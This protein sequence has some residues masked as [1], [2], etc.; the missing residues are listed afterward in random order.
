MFFPKASNVWKSH[1]QAGIFHWPR[2]KSQWLQKWIQHLRVSAVTRIAT[3]WKIESTYTLQ[4]INISHLGKRKI[5]FKMPFLGDVLVSWRVFYKYVSEKVKPSDSSN[6]NYNNNS[7]NHDKH[8]SLDLAPTLEVSMACKFYA[9]MVFSPTAS[10]PSSVW[11]VFLCH[12]RKI[13][14]QKQH[15]SLPFFQ[16]QV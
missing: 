4:G 12:G 13:Y 10:T 9:T 1:F 7:N 2:H 16:S 11:M 15:V 5:I 14:Q 6:D 8:Y 3:F